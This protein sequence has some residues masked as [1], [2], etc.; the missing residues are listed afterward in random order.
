MEEYISDCVIFLDNRV[1]NQIATRRLR[2]VKYR[3]SAHGTNE[4]PAMIDETGLS[5]L[6]VSSLRLDHGVSTER[7]A[8]GVAALD[9]MFGGQGFYRGSSVLISGTAGTGKSSFAA[10]FAHAACRRGERCLYFAYEESPAQIVGNMASIGFD[11]GRWVNEGRM[12]FHAVRPTFYGLEQ[13][14]VTIHKLVQELRPDC[15]VIDPVTNL[16]AV[17]AQSE[18]TAML[19]RVIDHLKQDGITAL[20]TS[21]TGAGIA[22]EQTDVAVSSLI[23][24]W[25]LLQ[26]EQTAAERRR[27]LYIL[28]SRGMGHSTELRE[29]RLTDQ[30]IRLEG[31]P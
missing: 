25:V 26:Q 2:I 15:V 23:D 14:L 6:P 19:T 20:F 10:A 9:A 13:H 5:V 1:A 30:G 3:G 27:T 24:T 17:G 21:L 22:S 11:L 31:A 8:T 12:R 29:L 18:V 16:G 28:K 4:Y 7:V